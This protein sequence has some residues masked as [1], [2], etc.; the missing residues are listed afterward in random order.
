MYLD[1][2]GGQI[3]EA[4]FAQLEFRVAAFCHRMKVAMQEIATGF[5][6]H[7]YTAKVITDAGQP[8]TRQVAKGHTFA[9]LFGASGFGRSK[10]EAAYYKHFNQK[11]HRYS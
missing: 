11:Y 9:P 3:L 10:A 8:T 4:D 7:A 6:V 5:D 1:G 2:Q